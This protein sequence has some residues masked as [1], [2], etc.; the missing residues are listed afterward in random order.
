MNYRVT[1][2]RFSFYVSFMQ[3]DHV[4]Q[5]RHVAL[6]GFL[7]CIGCQTTK[8]DDKTDLKKDTKV[9]SKNTF[10]ISGSSSIVEYIDSSGNAI[11][12]SE[13]S[14]FEK[15][16]IKEGGDLLVQIN[17]ITTDIKFMP[18]PTHE[19]SVKSYVSQNGKYDKLLWEINKTNEFPVGIWGGFDTYFKTVKKGCCGEEDGYTL[20]YLT[21]GNE[22]L[23][24]FRRS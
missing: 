3:V 14:Y 6:L 23:T 20:Y 17:V 22:Y 5:F 18:K 10:S 7:I 9:L 8:H 15:G 16:T 11:T 13:R 21:T 19:L 24:F 4:S 12:K 2:E 1:I